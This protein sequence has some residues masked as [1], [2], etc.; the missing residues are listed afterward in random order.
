MRL[1]IALDLGTTGCR[2]VAFDE[3]GGLVASH[4]LEYGVSHPEPGAAEQEAEGWWSAS[5]ACVKAVVAQL[6]DPNQVAGIGVSAQ[7]HSWVPTDAD[8]RPLRPALTWLDTRASAVARELLQQRGLP[9]WGHRA[10]KAPG[11]WHALCQ[12]IWLRTQEP[13]IALIAARYLF[14][15][16]FL[17]ARLTGVAA[18]DF[19]TAAGSLL[20]NLRE[21]EWDRALGFEYGVD[22]RRFAPVQAA[23]TVAGSL[24]RDVAADLGLTVGIPVAVGAQDQKCAALAAGL[25][26]GVAT[27][28]L[29]TSTAIAALSRQPAFDEATRIP[30]FPYLAR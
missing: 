11:P 19:T 28:S 2:A 1:V 27:I 20:L 9:F 29:G 24:L 3:A 17:V 12:L 30:C 6:G 15:H 16:D 7:G 26:E 22:V 8:F 23:A 13:Q 4:Y 25:E 21:F 18:T 14:A 10:G 5:R